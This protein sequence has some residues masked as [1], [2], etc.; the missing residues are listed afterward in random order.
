MT[1]TQEI[2]AAKLQSAIEWLDTKWVCHPINRVKRLES[3]LPEVF[4]WKPATV[5]TKDWKKKKPT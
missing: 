3:P 5:L 2:H 1:P 4:T